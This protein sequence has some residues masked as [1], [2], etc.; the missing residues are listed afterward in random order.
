MEDIRKLQKS[1]EYR[2]SYCQRSADS[3][4]NKIAKKMHHMYYNR[5]MYISKSLSEFSFQKKKEN[6]GFSKGM[7]I[8]KATSKLV[9]IWC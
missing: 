4:V 8:D 1:S 3:L 6:M 7:K 9:R 2:L 5:K